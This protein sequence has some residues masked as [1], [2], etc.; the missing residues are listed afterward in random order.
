MSETGFS[1]KRASE[2]DTLVE[3]LTDWI[4]DRGWDARMLSPNGD[5]P[6]IEFTDRDSKRAYLELKTRKEGQRNY[7]VKYDCLRRSLLSRRV[8]YVFDGKLIATAHQVAASIL[9]GPFRPNG[10]GSNTDYVLV[11]PCN[12]AVP[13]VDYFPDISGSD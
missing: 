11:N 13:L 4:R 3:L 12:T 5:E 10:N 2:H 6:D 7:A 8:Y 1:S 9:K